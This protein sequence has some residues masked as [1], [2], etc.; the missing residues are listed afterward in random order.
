VSAG[1][2]SS[3]WGG[4]TPAWRG[5]LLGCAAGV[6]LAEG[7]LLALGTGYFT[8]GFN[9]VYVDG[10]IGV[11]L[12][13]LGAALLDAALVLGIWSLA[14]PVLKR[15]CDTRLELWCAA[16][17]LTLLVALFPA[18]A[19]YN[20][21]VT[22]GRL[23]SVSL[24]QVGS[25]GS[26]VNAASVAVDEL[27][28][29]GRLAG[30][31]AL[32][33]CLA[34]LVLAR[35]VGRGLGVTRVRL[36]PPPTRSLWLTW[37]TVACAALAVFAASA[38][39]AP[40]LHYG[41]AYKTS[42]SLAGGL[43]RR[44]TDF[45]RDGYGLLS[46]P[47]DAA[48]L[49]ASVHPYAPDEPGNGLDEN[50]WAGDHPPGFSAPS[51][52]PRRGGPAAVTPHFLLVY[53]ESFRADLLDRRLAGR[54]ITPFLNRLAA[55]GARSE[56]AFVH[57][58]WTLPSRA[59][60]FGGSLAPRPGEP[61]LVDDFKARGYT[62]AW[63]SGQDD[64]YGN[65]VALAGADRADVF[66]DARDDVQRRTSRSTAAVSLQV[67]WKTVLE[68]VEAYLR[69]ADPERPLFL[70]VNLVDTHFPYHHDELDD[71]LG[72]APL[73][74]RDIRRDRAE[75]VRGAYA[76][77]AANVDR[78]IERLVRA[79]R[80]RL[81]GRPQAILVT[82]DHGQ[83][84]YETGTLGHGQELLQAQTRVPFVLWGLGGVW[85]EPIA[86]SDV[87]GLLDRNLFLPR[88]G[89][90]PRASLQPEAERRILQ[91]LG[92][93]ARPQQLGLR[94]IGGITRY[95]LRRATATRLD[96]DERPL[97][98]PPPGSE[99]RSL[100]WWWESLQRQLLAAPGA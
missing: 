67:S 83:S 58:P 26:A 84:F 96:A 2:K 8:G 91:Y 25:A 57:S 79:W 64:A 18:V 38:L 52:Q 3:A 90:T 45:D 27:P 32:L 93:L 39:G 10:A 14:L 61:T 50:G 42:G 33:A 20:L 34:L 85:P 41:L 62:V 73:E 72:V 82:G 30:A 75:R 80:A 15:A 63:F 36:E 13:L 44:L 60:L 51:P 29:Y 11:V 53:L 97:P 16:G 95:D 69:D 9:S 86:P 76:N 28:D 48:P 40:S 81:A 19:R 74:R 49:D 78:G 100:I 46:Q 68:R 12:Y 47:P 89:A 5:L 66:Y 54:E 37:L 77:A 4:W 21:H 98:G 1:A 87:R 24:L 94:G 35:R 65:S 17:L 71:I 7:V 70:Y 23:V 6:L 55:E 99:V 59:Q 43:A 92:E 56:H 88:Q 31:G 22:L